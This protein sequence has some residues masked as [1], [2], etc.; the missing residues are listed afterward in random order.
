MRS[1]RFP[2]DFLGCALVVGALGCGEDDANDASDSG[3]SSSGGSSGASTGG[4]GQTGGS[5]GGGGEL[6][7]DRTGGAL[8]DF[9]V[10][11]D[12][13]RVWIENDA[14]IEEAERLLQAHEMRIPVFNELVDGTDCDEQW[15]WH[16][17]PSDVDFADFTIEVC[18]GVPSYIEENKAEWLSSGGSYCPWSAQVTAVTRR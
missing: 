2:L 15:T 14:F 5:S 4:T 1:L 8:I 7:E 3:G 16:P 6:C 12:T 10:G 17:D 18:D 9:A 11:D 13:L